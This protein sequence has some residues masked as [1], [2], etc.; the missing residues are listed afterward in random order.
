MPH[1]KPESL[2]CNFG[3]LLLR[4]C[5]RW[6]EIGSSIDSGGTLLV[7]FLYHFFNRVVSLLMASSTAISLSSSSV[8]I[9][10]GMGLEKY[11][12]IP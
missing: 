9:S 11:L 6:V 2:A 3:I 8:T 12:L 7:S 4:K 5:G 1:H 10:D